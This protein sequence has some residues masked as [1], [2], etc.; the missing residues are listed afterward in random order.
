MHYINQ[1]LYSISKPQATMN[2]EIPDTTLTL[3]AL[4]QAAL[5][6]A[7]AAQADNT[8]PN[9]LSDARQT[10]EKARAAQDDAKDEAQ[11]LVNQFHEDDE[12]ALE[13][14]T[15][16][17]EYLTDAADYNDAADLLDHCEHLLEK[18]KPAT[19]A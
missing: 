1:L 6:L 12:E 14:P 18:L 9:N 8:S 17:L 2:N 13:D 3:T 5:D 16:F 11:D 19:P 4:A 10:Y 15:T 7:L